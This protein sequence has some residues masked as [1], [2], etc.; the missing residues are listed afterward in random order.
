MRQPES[1][2]EI[3]CAECGKLLARGEVLILTIKCPRCKTYNTLR[4][5]S[6]NPECQEQSQELPYVASW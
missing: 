1:L 5:M 4:A 6:P 2:S 3:R